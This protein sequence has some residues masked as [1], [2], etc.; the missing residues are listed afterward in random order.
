M[1]KTIHIEWVGRCFE[2][3]ITSLKPMAALPALAHQLSRPLDKIGNL[4][5][6]IRARS[7]RTCCLPPPILGKETE[8]SENESRNR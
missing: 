6:V 8:L 1:M 5:P 4:R 2:L 3:A 7:N